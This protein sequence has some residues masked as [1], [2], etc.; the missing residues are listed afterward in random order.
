M[1]RSLQEEMALFKVAVLEEAMRPVFAA[2][3]Q[4]IDRKYPFQLE[5]HTPA[6]MRHTNVL[7]R[8][9]TRSETLEDILK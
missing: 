7:S 3:I 5:Q 1:F 6:V 9:A 2:R 8:E 4:E